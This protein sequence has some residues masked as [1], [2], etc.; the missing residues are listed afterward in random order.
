MLSIL[1]IVNYL[2]GKPLST[3]ILVILTATIY[4]YIFYY[5]WDTV[6]ENNV[7]FITIIILFLMDITTIIY[8]YTSIS[9]SND[10]TKKIK[11]VK[12][13]KEKKVEPIETS[14]KCN[15]EDK[16]KCNVEDKEK[17]IKKNPIE[18]ISI[19]KKD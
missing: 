15:L 10:D 5:L 3:S 18:D 8:L 11:D 12:D 4:L 2:F 13:K 14:D 17:E 7:Y 16:D 1:N 19:F 6:K 9:K